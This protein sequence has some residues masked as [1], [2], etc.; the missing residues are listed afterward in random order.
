[1]DPTAWP[2]PRL[3]GLHEHRR[4]QSLESASITAA[5]VSSARVNH[6]ILYDLRR[7][8]LPLIKSHRCLELYP[9][10]LNRPASGCA[11]SDHACPELKMPPALTGTAPREPAMQPFAS[12]MQSRSESPIRTLEL[13]YAFSTP[14]LQQQSGCHAATSAVQPSAW[15]CRGLQEAGRTPWSRAWA[16]SSSGFHEPGGRRNVT[17]SGSLE[18]ASS[19]SVRCSAG[20]TGRLSTDGRETDDLGWTGRI[21]RLTHGGDD[22]LAPNLALGRNSTVA[23]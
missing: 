19:I 20:S 14:V 15:V 5:S 17:G 16:T 22:G 18:S 6:K 4:V 10:S 7:L 2:K 8:L 3:H 1:M 21:E 23:R 11:G 13:D 12:S 9:A